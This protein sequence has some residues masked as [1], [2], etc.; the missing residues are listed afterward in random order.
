M[1]E[2]EQAVGVCLYQLNAKEQAV[3]QRVLSFSGTQAQHF[4][5]AELN[6]ANIVVVADQSE[7]ALEQLAE[8]DCFLIRIMDAG[9]TLPCD[10]EL[11]RPLLVTRVM[12][13]LEEARKLWLAGKTPDELTLDGV[14]PASPT[15]LE[16]IENT[17]TQVLAP[18]S[19][20]SLA[21]EPPHHEPTYHHHALVVDDSAA[22]RKQLE[23][24]LAQA[25]IGADFAEDGEQALVKIAE[26]RYDL[27]F[28]DIIMPGM[29]GFET[30]RQMRLRKEMKKTPIIMLSAK[31]SPLDEVQ[32]VI[33]GASTYLTKP[34][35]T[36]Q[37]QKTLKRVSAWL[38][39][40]QSH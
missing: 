1:S 33:A 11:H 8:Q 23:L 13:T 24:E 30:C 28:L 22:I 15:P 2:M 26:R 25:G 9:N 36:E 29:D 7:L 40:Y 6:Q 21:T 18:P 34:V 39:N 20:I 14:K 19:E 17:P 3:V 37:L 10:V 32:G 27:V 31:T 16:T 38:D 35:K 4:K 5:T 12:R